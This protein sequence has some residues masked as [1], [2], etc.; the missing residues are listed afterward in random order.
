MSQSV[1]VLCQARLISDVGAWGV[2]E[3]YSGYKSSY[4][5]N[6]VHGFL[7][8]DLDLCLGLGPLFTATA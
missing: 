7:G 5:G 6:L 3:K 8:S 2:G 1:I 4:I